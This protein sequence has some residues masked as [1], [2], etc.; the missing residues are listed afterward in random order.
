MY[1]NKTPA[2]WFL[3]ELI[4]RADSEKYSFFVAISVCRV[5]LGL[6]SLF[7]PSNFWLAGDFLY[8][9]SLLSLLRAFCLKILIKIDRYIK[10]SFKGET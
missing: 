8:S 2:E 7:N 5:V 1:G 3:F 9:M 4:Y 6:G 10:I